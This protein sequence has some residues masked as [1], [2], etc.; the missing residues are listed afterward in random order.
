M[1]RTVVP[2]DLTLTSE[3]FSCISQGPEGNS[4]VHEYGLRT[5]SL[6]PAH[7][8]VPWLVVNGVHNKETQRAAE[9]DLAKLVCQSYK[10]KDKPKECG[11]ASVQWEDRVDISVMY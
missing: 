1:S 3:L 2:A 6:V 4:L 7:K 8:Y 11:D 10:G 9:T 5:E